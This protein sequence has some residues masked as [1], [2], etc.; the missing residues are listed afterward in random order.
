MRE[1]VLVIGSINLDIVGS[2]GHYPKLGETI[3]ATNTSLSAGGKGANQALSLQKMGIDVVMVGRTG[4]DIFADLALSELRKYHV[5]LTEVKQNEKQSTGLAMIWVDKNGNNS[6]VVSPGANSELSATGIHDLEGLFSSSA[7]LVIQLEIPIETV[8]EAAKTAKKH[9]IP[10]ILN[11][12]PAAE[13]SDEMFLAIDV[14]ICNETEASLLTGIE[15]HA[16]E[17]AKA[18]ARHLLGKIGEGKV[19]ITL[20][21]M[22]TIYTENMEVVNYQPAFKVE[23]IDSVGAGDAF[24]GGLAACLIWKMP[25]KEAVIWGNAC[26][27][28]ATTRRG[29]Q[30]SLPEMKEVEIFIR[31]HQ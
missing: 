26:G 15:I 27:A 21:E 10:V 19:I 31:S 11:S 5:D 25:L 28:I 4:Q 2:V 24:V 12:A 23:P 16:I 9:G 7:A 14:L 6:I 20:G 1:K 3:L 17:E 8:F 29:A 13:L 30:I 22:G 18:A